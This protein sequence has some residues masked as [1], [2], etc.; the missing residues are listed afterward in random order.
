MQKEELTSTVAGL[1]H[2]LELES[3]KSQ[4]LESH[5][6]GCMQAL[7]KLKS[8]HEET[9]RDLEHTGRDLEECNMQLASQQDMC[10]QELDKLK[11]DLEQT[12]HD[13]KESNTALYVLLP[14]CITFIILLLILLHT[15]IFA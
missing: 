6:D 3:Q 2:R 14:A 11:S 12:R 8:D 15:S 13:L 9:S 10:K 4:T 7:A 1:T 5:Q